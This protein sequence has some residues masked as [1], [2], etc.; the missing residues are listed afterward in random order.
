M[1]AAGTATCPAT[2]ALGGGY[3]PPQR[4][5]ARPLGGE[6][7]RS[8]NLPSPP[9]CGGPGLSPEQETPVAFTCTCSFS[10]AH[11]LP[12]QQVPPRRPPFPHPS[13]RS[14]GT[15]RGA[16]AGEGGLLRK[17]PPPLA[18]RLLTP[19]D[20]LDG[21]AAGGAVSGQ[22]RRW[23]Q[24]RS[25]ARRRPRPLRALPSPRVT[26]GRAP[27]APGPQRGAGAQGEGPGRRGGA[28]RAAPMRHARGGAV[29]RPR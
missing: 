24:G 4:P 8:S 14:R 3:N 20:A 25:P 23:R 9:A 27:A 21:P 1:Q 7:A 16:E 18:P 6:Q 28:A 13:R 5:Q 19:P 2:D 12:V 22:G 11:P 17:S 26:R 15:P 10:S 29:P